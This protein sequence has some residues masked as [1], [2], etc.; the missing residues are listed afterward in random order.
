VP[1]TVH[2]MMLP[3]PVNLPV[4]ALLARVNHDFAKLTRSSAHKYIRA[5]RIYVRDLFEIVNHQ[6]LVSHCFSDFMEIT[7]K[8]ILKAKAPEP[9]KAIK[10]V[11]TI[12][13]EQVPADRKTPF[14]K[15]FP[16][17][18]PAEDYIKKTSA[19]ASVPVAVA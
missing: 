4:S 17:E 1:V 15:K 2:N 10:E 11:T 12:K 16:N 6:S 5:K 19:A 14:S 13:V 3:V 8:A 9:S 18:K 7:V